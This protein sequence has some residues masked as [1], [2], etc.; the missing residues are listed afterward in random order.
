[1]DFKNKVVIVTG[2][3][4]GI[5]AA[6]V[7]RLAAEGARVVVNYSRNASAAEAT[8]QSCRD[9]GGETLLVKADV[10]QDADCRRMAQAALDAWGRIDALVNNAGTTRFVGLR[11]LDGLSAEDFQK[12]YAV[13]V[14]GAFQMA[15][16][17]AAA[18]RASH[19]AIVN[20]PSWVEIDDTLTIAPCESRKAVAHARAIWNAP[21]TFTA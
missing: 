18:L 12:I 11:D 14:I 5:G 19:G 6:C 21:I 7:Q 3:A 4:T 2:S 17:C 20:V 10:A 8:A 16:A 9:A 1:M 13:N 15:R